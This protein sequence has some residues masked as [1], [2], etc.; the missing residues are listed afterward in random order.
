[1]KRSVL[2]LVPVLLIGVFAAP[3]SASRAGWSVTPSPNPRAG[4]GALNTVSCPTASVCTAVGLYVRESGLGV[5]LAERRSGGRWTV[6]STPNPAGAAASALN[7]VSCPSGS[8]C[9]AVGSFAAGSGVRL[10][11]AERWDGRSWRI[12][13]TPS[14]PG[15]PFS[16]LAAVAC[17]AADSCTAV[18]ASNSKLLVERWDGARWRIQPAPVPAGAQFSGLSGVTCTAVA[19]CIAVGDYVSSSGA[20]VTLAE[21]WNGVRWSIQATPSPAGAAA[22]VLFGVSCTS[23]SSCMAAGTAFTSSGPAGFSERWNGA[24]WHLLGVPA[25]PGAQSSLLLN[26]SCAAVSCEAVGEYNDSF[27]ATVTLGERWNGTTWHAQPT[28]NPAR[29]G[30]RQQPQRRVLPRGV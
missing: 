27:G 20:D 9:T 12:Q 3:A 15:S 21:R 1:M 25:P 5:T 2:L 24:A 8:A 13:A 22:A 17:P 11:L 4:N 28:P 10:T 18:G 6:Q 26:V 30:G 7:G 16:I 29:A 19:S 14:P 23:G